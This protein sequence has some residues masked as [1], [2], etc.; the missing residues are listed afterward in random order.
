[1]A[2]AETTPN[3]SKT[4]PTLRRRKVLISANVL[5]QVVVV[6]L[7]VVMVNWLASRHYLRFDWTNVSYYKLS[8]K[9]KQVLQ[10]LKSP[11]DVVVFLQPSA[12]QPQVAKIY[13]DVRNLLKEFQYFGQK[14][15]RI[16]YVD[17]QGDPHR[18]EQLVAKY[19]VDSP[20]VVIFASGDRHKYVTADELVEVDMSQMGQGYRIK[21]FKGEGAFLSAIQNVTESRQPVIYFLTGHGERDPNSMDEREGY[22]L[23]SQYIKRDNLK[24]E[25]WNLAEK[26]ALPEDVGV[27]V[28]A[29]PTKKLSPAELG[30]LDEYLQK[31]GGRLFLMLDPRRETGLEAFLGR[32]GVQ[33]DNNLAMAKGGTVLGT[34]VLM[35]NALGR[36]Y[37]PHPITKKLEGVNTEFPYARTVRRGQGEPPGGGAPVVTE[38]VKTPVAYWGETDLEAK[39]SKFDEGQDMQG[40]LS[41]AVA[42]EA[43][44]PPGVELEAGQYRMVV[45]GTSGFV[46]NGGITDSN[47]DFFLNSMNWLLQ[48]EALVA[49]GPK[50]PQEFRLD[51]TP[52]QAQAVKLLV[53]AGLPLAV[54]VFGFLVY[55]RRR[56]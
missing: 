34:E 20:N 3:S 18:A 8:D 24:I 35:V 5:V 54:A 46:D 40:P 45:V 51:M 13:E 44:K 2:M 36:N 43:L 21:A 15:L 29:G 47:L 31:K 53:A 17:P 32:W 28:V 38:L 25:Q 6:F 30:Q 12:Q 33:V 56:K 16:E 10:G 26:Q 14:N 23:L 4:A 11:L 49:V 52:G 50:E 48:R 55:L 19:K 1:M 7:L 9:T 37:A 22:S 39:R 27:L 41:L 42:V